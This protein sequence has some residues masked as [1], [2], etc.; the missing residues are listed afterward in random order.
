[1]WL[2]PPSV[3]HRYYGGSLPLGKPPQNMSS[4]ELRDYYEYRTVEQALA[5][6]QLI[7][8]QVRAVS[9]PPCNICG[10]PST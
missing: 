9:E 7:V 2:Y 6:Y 10:C 4:T 3:Q 1:M 5:D 8:G